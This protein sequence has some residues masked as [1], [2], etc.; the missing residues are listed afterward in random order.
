M[1]GD[2]ETPMAPKFKSKSCPSTDTGEDDLFGQQHDQAIDDI[3]ADFWSDGTLSGNAMVGSSGSES[4]AFNFG[5][6]DTDFQVG[7]TSTP[8]G[9]G[10]GLT[11]LDLDYDELL[12][13]C[14]GESVPTG[15]GI[16]WSTSSGGAGLSAQDVDDLLGLAQLGTTAGSSGDCG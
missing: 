8:A 5:F 4:E 2:L 13:W 7:E 12:K 15:G 14:G 11:D 6:D 3:F 1:F 9:E 10:G 16:G